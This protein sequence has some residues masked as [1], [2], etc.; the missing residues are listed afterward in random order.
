MEWININQLTKEMVSARLSELTDPV[1]AAVEILEKTV[2]IALKDVSGLTPGHRQT[3]VAACQ[4]TLTALLV[5]EYD[6][7]PAST[8]IVHAMVRIA[9]KIHQDPTELTTLALHAIAD[10]R[11]FLPNET[12]G[13]IR[14]AIDADFMGAGNAL[15]EIL[16]SARMAQAD[17][18]IP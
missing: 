10:M 7:V 18:P 16:D 5:K 6:L 3:V 2:S 9:N 8:K 17:A 1:D 11:R 12:M 13:A 14:H 4:G 15:Q